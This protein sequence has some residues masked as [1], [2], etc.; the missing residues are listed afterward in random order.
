MPLHDVSVATVHDRLYIFGG[1]NGDFQ[2]D[3]F[4]NTWIKSLLLN[5]TSNPTYSPTTM[6]PTNVPT[7]KPSVYPTTNPTI[8]PTIN[9]TI[10]P[11][12]YP[13]KIPTYE[14]TYEPTYNPTNEPTYEPTYNPTYEPTY[15]PSYNPTYEP[16]YEPTYYPTVFPTE[17]PSFIPSSDPTYI[18]TEQQK[19]DSVPIIQ[20]NSF[21]FSIVMVVGSIDLILTI[22]CLVYIVMKVR[23]RSVKPGNASI[24]DTI[25]EFGIIQYMQIVSEIFDIA[26]DYFYAA[27]L[28]VT[29]TDDNYAA[30]LILLGWLSLLFS[31]SGLSIFFFKYSTYRKLIAKQAK[32]LKN[33]LNACKNDNERDAIT[34]EI[35]YRTMDITIISLLNGCIEDV[36]QTLIILIA[37]S[38]I[39]WNYI[40]ILTISFSIISFTSK[41]SN[42][43][44][45][46][47]GCMDEPTIRNKT[48]LE[49]IQQ[50]T[51]RDSN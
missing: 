31:I 19:S 35:R 28:I 1:F 39:K 11:T 49:M 27:S 30:S 29:P 36:P 9:P 37:T 6:N 14:P 7:K 26:T 8:Y 50:N 33:Q 38:N 3:G 10:H 40:S 42:V 22:F 12:I 13:S 15:E 41:L 16:T 43:I 51:P 46:K 32:T 20:T 17:M 2:Y 21:L 34:Q 18:T 23:L 48:Q 5:P 25:K 45:T 24:I 4:V 47:F 44:V